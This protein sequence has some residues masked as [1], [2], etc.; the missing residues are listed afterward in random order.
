MNVF[1]SYSR[2]DQGFA[3][4]LAKTLR[5]N[6]HSV[7]SNADTRPGDEY[8]KVIAE[9]IA[10][11]DAIIP[12]ISEK[13]AR[14]GAMA[15]EIAMALSL[16]GKKGTQIIPVVLGR[17]TKVP[18]ELA[19][20]QCVVIPYE[21]FDPNVSFESREELQAAIANRGLEPKEKKNNID[22]ILLSLSVRDHEI[23]DEKAKEKASEEKVQAGLS[24]Y[25][26]RC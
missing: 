20:F 19:G 23:K 17:D 24:A 13:S 7:F 18:A 9:G 2:H 11:A 16:Y 25:L 12:V 5:E 22:K 15:N 10:K 21:S 4:E 6:G 14:D 1:I 26:N 3:M 8:H